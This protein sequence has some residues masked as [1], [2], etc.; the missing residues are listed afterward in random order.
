MTRLQARVGRGGRWIGVLVIGLGLG[1]GGGT[2]SAG[3]TETKSKDGMTGTIV[4]AGSLSAII[5]GVAWTSAANETI[6]SSSSA[7]SGQLS[8]SGTQGSP[9]SYTSLSFALGFIA[10]P[11]TYPLGVNQGSTPGGTV[12]VV[13]IA[14]TTTF[15]DWMTDFSGTAG[16][17]TFATLASGQMTGSFMFTALPQAGG[18]ATNTRVVTDGM[19]D[20]AYPDTFTLPSGDNTG[21]T[22]SAMLNGQPWYAATVEGL[23]DASTGVLSLAGMTTGITLSITTSAPVAA[24]GTYDQSAITMQATGTG[25]NCCWVGTN[26]T[27]SVTVTSLTSARAAGTFTA[28]LPVS[29]GGT[30]TAPLTITDGKFDLLIS[31]AS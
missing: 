9:T 25:A 4:G 21:N 20:L 18:T 6:V 12:T 11:G 13:S 23:G 5:D 8:V 31:A 3:K 24:G 10:G 29:T 27:I 19:F 28:T 16:T 2:T 14:S 15:N 26:G 22:M 1:C 17:I 7:S 30:A